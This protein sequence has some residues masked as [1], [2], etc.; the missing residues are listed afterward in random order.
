MTPAQ[1]IEVQ[2]WARDGKRLLIGNVLLEID[3]FTS[4]N[5]RYGFAMGRTNAEGQ[6]SVSYNYIE[7]LRSSNARENLMDYNT[8]LEACDPRV[9]IV[10]PSDRHLREKCDTAVRFYSQVPEWAKDWPSNGQVK[11]VQVE[12]ML[13]GNITSIHIQAE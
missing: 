9:R 1:S 2:L 7:Q 13:C 10:I 12:V 5:Y 4:G 3:F 8:R 11:A 6:V